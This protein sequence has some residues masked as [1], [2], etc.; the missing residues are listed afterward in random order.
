MG[1]ENQRIGRVTYSSAL[2]QSGKADNNNSSSWPSGENSPGKGATYSKEAT[3]GWVERQ[4]VLGLKDSMRDIGGLD[5]W[6]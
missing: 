4:P 5:T 6:G 1:L 3:R 2:G